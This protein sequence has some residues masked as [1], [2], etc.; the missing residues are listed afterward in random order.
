MLRQL[1]L[2]VLLVLTIQLGVHNLL[3]KFDLNDGLLPV[4]VNLATILIVWGV[5]V[6]FTRSIKQVIETLEL[7]V[8]CFQDNDFSITIQNKRGDDE[9]GNIIEAYN[10]V[11]QTIRK[12]RMNLYQRELLLD[13]IIQETP[14]AL[15]LTDINDVV[16]YSNDATKALFN[17]AEK[18]DGIVFSSLLK[19]LPAALKK[20][21]IEKQQGLYTEQVDQHKSVFY[22]NCQTFNLNRA[23]HYLYLYKNMTTEISRQEIDL[24]KNAIR[25]M[26]HELNNSLAPI[27][28]LTNSAKD[29]LTKPQHADMLPDI[30][31]TISQRTSRLHTFI[32]QYARFA[33][34]PL[35][36]LK[37]VSLIDFI[38]T[39][40]QLC[41]Y[42][43]IGEI[44]DTAV[45]IDLGQMEQVLINLLKNAK[46]SGS[47][48]EEVGLEISLDAHKRV[49]FSITD[50]GSGM[51][52]SQLQQALL[53]FFSTK[54]QGTGLGLTLCN[55]IVTAHGGLL[56][57]VNR[58]GGGLEIRFSLPAC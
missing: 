33:R 12:E 43:P 37:T 3:Q 21:T 5:F 10:K 28:S 38:K 52:E 51:T 45:A 26:S 50:R 49:I 48:I 15:V 54:Q 32:D 30:L 40:V 24:W 20:A 8:K 2:L 17:V 9:L 1:L 18:P 13:T 22:L 57:I 44:P 25:L 58:E 55:E 36:S 34:L 42:Q 27:A 31:D 56:R 35:P 19:V 11:A 29:I 16:V 41:E 7:G 47:K 53:P 46:E 4:I 39:I 6:L 14:V 23:E